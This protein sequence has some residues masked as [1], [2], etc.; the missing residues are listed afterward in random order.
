MRAVWATRSFLDY[1][2]PVYAALDRL[3]EGNLHVVY[4]KDVTPQRA[5]Q[6]LE[7]ALGPRAIGFTGERSVG[8][9]GNITT[10]EAN[11]AI[12]LP[13]QKGIYDCIDALRPDVLIGDGF[14][15][16][17][18]TAALHRLVH[19]TPLVVLYE[20]T[21][22]TERRAQWYRRAFRRAVVSLT[23]AM[24]CNGTLSMQ[25]A[26][27][28]GMPAGRIT[29][30]HM[31]AETEGIAKRASAVSAQ[32][33]R[34]F[35]HS[36]NVADGDVLFLCVGQ[37]IPRK[38]MLELLAGI[39]RMDDEV[40]SRC[41]FVLV[42]EG[43]QRDEIAMRAAALGLSRLIMPGPMDYDSI[44]LAY[45]SADYFLMPTLE[46]NWSLVVPEAMSCGL[47][48]LCSIYNGCHPEFA[49]EGA[50]GW[51]FDP[52][53]PANTARALTEACNTQPQ[54]RAAMGQASRD[55]VAQHGPEQAALSILRAIDMARAHANSTRR[56]RLRQ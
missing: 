36:F 25:Y 32:Q 55:I 54:L 3:L 28:L 4:N 10:I 44:H 13:Y 53:D 35:R 17:T 7:A 15:Q 52:L 9:K 48:V 24:G 11:R 43:P 18:W 5:W 27:G 2:V 39:G 46:D 1:R 47:P 33:R 6:K 16:W 45:A 30:G 22:H 42:G 49:I 34:E 31:S 40:K 41:A 12:R 38:G 50:N 26:M 21:A 14:F 56:A 20:R 8:Y 19:G 29:T 23:D 51:A 37:L